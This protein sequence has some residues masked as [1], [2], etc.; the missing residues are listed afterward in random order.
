VWPPSIILLRPGFHF[1]PG[2]NPENG[3]IIIIDREGDFLYEVEGL[4]EGVYGL[5]I[6]N[7]RNG[8]ISEFTGL[9]M[10][11]HTGEIHQYVVD[12]VCS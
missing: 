3:S 5:Q 1:V 8:A 10:P 12:W 9:A 11:V 7:T 6:V 4:A 2:V